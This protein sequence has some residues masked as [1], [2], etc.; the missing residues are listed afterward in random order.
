MNDV[1]RRS[2]E[3]RVTE[4]VDI[5]ELGEEVVPA[6]IRRGYDRHKGSD[7]CVEMHLPHRRGIAEVED[8]AVGEAYPVTVAVTASDHPSVLN[9]RSV[10]GVLVRALVMKSEAER[11]G[12]RRFS[13]QR[14]RTSRIDEARSS[15]A[16]SLSHL[17]APD[18]VRGQGQ[19]RVGRR[20]GLT[21]P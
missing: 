2:V 12:E 17:R 15:H 19:L 20:H 11:A 3:R 13:S 6:A 7:L 9:A 14:L 5:A 4:V 18:S 21:R 16:V 10:I 1:N 8:R